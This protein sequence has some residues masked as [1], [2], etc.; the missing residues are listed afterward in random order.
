[1]FMCG[2]KLPTNLRRNK[3]EDLYIGGLKLERA[4]NSRG[5]DYVLVICCP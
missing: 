5:D 3:N 4:L 1:M 2:R